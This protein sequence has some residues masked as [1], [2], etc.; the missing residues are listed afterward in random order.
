MARAEGIGFSEWDGPNH[1]GAANPGTQDV[2]RL[3]IGMEGACALRKSSF[4]AR[5]RG[6]LAQGPLETVG[7]THEREASFRGGNGFVV[8]FSRSGRAAFFCRLA[9]GCHSRAYLQ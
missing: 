8:S 6:V 3:F 1:R 2:E 9:T 7:R 4:H 5:L